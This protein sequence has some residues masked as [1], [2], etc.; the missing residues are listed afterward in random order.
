[1]L[2]SMAFGDLYTHRENDIERVIHL[3]FLCS[4]KNASKRSSHA[5]GLFALRVAKSGEII[6]VYFPYLY[7]FNQGHG[8]RDAFSLLRPRV[9]SERDP[10]WPSGPTNTHKKS[11]FIGWSIGCFAT[12]MLKNIRN[13]YQFILIIPKC[14]GLVTSRCF[15]WP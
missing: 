3:E 9:H 6:F 13:I 11:L 8:H 2:P 5:T 10:K 14:T 4:Y 12:L 7:I 15:Q 1:M